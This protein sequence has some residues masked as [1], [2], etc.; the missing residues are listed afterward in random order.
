MG[1]GTHHIIPLKTFVYVLIA[2]LFLTV[3]TVAIGQVDFGEFNLI[4][5]MAIATV[6][7][8]LV[9]AF[10]MHLKYDDRFY[11]WIFLLGV[12]FLVVMFFFSDLDILTRVPETSTL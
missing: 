5:G 4:V 7:A 1:S 8:S 2:L 3:V 12:F 6:K 9:L 10:F 11:L